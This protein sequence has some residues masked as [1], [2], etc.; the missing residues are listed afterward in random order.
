MPAKNDDML[1]AK[2]SFVTS[3]GLSYIKNVT[4]VRASDP[5]AKKFKDLFQPLDVS[6][7]TLEAATAAPGEKRGTRR[8][9]PVRRA[10]AKVRNAVKAA[11]TP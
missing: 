10:A 7:P 3:E 2:E 6:Y 11:P 8:S 5:A 4:R 9:S 1:V